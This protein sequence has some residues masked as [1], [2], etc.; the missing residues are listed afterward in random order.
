ME[1]DGVGHGI[2]RHF[3][4]ARAVV[5]PKH[6]DDGRVVR[7]A[8]GLVCR[9]CSTRTESRRAVLFQQLAVEKRALA[10]VVC[11]DLHSRALLGPAV[12]D[13]FERELPLGAI[14]P[15]HVHHQ[16]TVGAGADVVVDP[17]ADHDVA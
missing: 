8:S 4:R 10:C 11:A 13:V 2:I 14:S 3:R 9:I 15:W 1:D 16:I 7:H 17:A 12:F 5:W 6:R